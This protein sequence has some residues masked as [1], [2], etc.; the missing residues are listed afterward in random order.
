M[1]I[2]RV[3]SVFCPSGVKDVYS[4][5]L[6]IYD[7]RIE[8]TFFADSLAFSR[9]RDRYLSSLAQHDVPELRALSQTCETLLT[10][11]DY[12]T[13]TPEQRQALEGAWEELRHACQIHAD[14]I[15]A[16]YPSLQTGYTYSVHDPKYDEE[17]R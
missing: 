15:E 16:R 14:A 5:C 11:Y 10:E 2:D 8:K 9:R 6:S 7:F 12:T 4:W 13:G 17:T 3:S 1:A